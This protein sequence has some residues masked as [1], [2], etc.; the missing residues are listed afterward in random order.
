MDY[1]FQFCQPK[2]KICDFNKY[3]TG[4]HM[5]IFQSERLRNVYKVLTKLERMLK[6][7]LVLTLHDTVNRKWTSDSL[8]FKPWKHKNP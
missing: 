7:Y 8:F 6:E 2:D 4:I 1:E 5:N 3:S